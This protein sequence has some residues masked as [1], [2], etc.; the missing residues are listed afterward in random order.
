MTHI[1]ELA[2]GPPSGDRERNIVLSH[3]HE[4]KAA[5]MNGWGWSDI[6]KALDQSPRALAAAFHRVETAI[7]KGKLDAGRLGGKTIKPASRPAGTAA[8]SNFT[9]LTISSGPKFGDAS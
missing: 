6:A 5:R 2:A 3:F 1:S 8:R 4:I 7:K 9:D